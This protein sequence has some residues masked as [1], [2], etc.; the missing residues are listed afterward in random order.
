MLDK[1]LNFFMYMEFLYINKDEKNK[2]WQIQ[3]V[4]KIN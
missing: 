4:L 2:N 3:A 1:G